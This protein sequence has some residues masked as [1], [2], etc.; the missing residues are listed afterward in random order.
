MNELE[1]SNNSL[2]KYFC[3]FCMF[4]AGG[5]MLLNS[6][7]INMGMMLFRLGGMGIGLGGLLVPFMLG[8]GWIFFNHKAISTVKAL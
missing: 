3:G 6:I 2:G 1:T 4:A 5:F 7:Q 8:I